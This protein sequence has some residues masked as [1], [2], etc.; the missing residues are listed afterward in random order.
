MNKSYFFKFI[1]S[2]L[3]TCP[4]VCLAAPEPWTIED[5]LDASSELS[6]QMR[7]PEA[8]PQ[9]PLPQVFVLVSF[10][11]P[12]ASLERLARDA[13]DAGIP[14]VFRGVPETKESTDSKLPLLNPQSLVAFQSLIDSGADVQ[15][16]PELVSEYNVRQVPALISSALLMLLSSSAVAYDKQSAMDA[17]KEEAA[18]LSIK[19][20]LTESS[21]SGTVPE[22]GSDV[23]ELKDLFAKGQ[24]NLLT[25]GSSKADGCLSQTSMDCRAV[26]VIYDTHSRPDWEE[27]DFDNILADRDHLLNK[28][29]D[30]PPNG[31]EICETITTTRPPQTDFSV[32]E[33]TTVG[34]STQSC[35][36]G[37]TEKLDVSTLFECI[38]RTGKKLTVECL[39]D[40]NETSQDYTCL[41][42]PPQTCHVGE[43]VQIHST[44]QYRCKTQQFEQNTY[45]CNRYLEVVGYSGC[46]IGKF[47]EAA[48][49]TSSSL[50]K[51][52]CNGGDVIELKYQCS[53]DLIPKLRI[54][55]NVKNS[56]NFGFDIQAEDFQSEHFFS[57]C[58]GVWTGQTR[59]TGVNCT[60]EIKMDIY[61][62]PGKWDYSGS[63]SKRFSFQKNVNDISLDK[64]RTTCVSDDGKV[65]E[66]ES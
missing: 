36:E 28:L 3:I 30:L 9:K 61:T 10:S 32:C 8:A 58:K 38:A 5:V 15:L 24:G 46:E 26:Q 52:T 62:R 63:I 57:N 66:F 25:P 47:F 17:A 35:F 1:L 31:Q 29:P 33:E 34:S 12:E 56:A 19:D 39:A 40:Y 48:S 59:C 14:L 21:A 45:R 7:Y 23:S 6:Q 13:K 51:D 37:W 50:G 2:D 41:H 18:R 65:V 49:E 54:E 60:V 43:K 20:I 4:L 22:Y 16:N 42:T 53:N 44:Y 11:M 55:T 27:S 64:W